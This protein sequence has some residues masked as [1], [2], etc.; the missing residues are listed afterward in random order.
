MQEY[1]VFT[2]F[3]INVVFVTLLGWYLITNLQWYDYKLSRVLFKHHKPQ[4]HIIYF[5]IPFVAYHTT[6][7]FF[8]IFFLF[9]ILPSII[10]WHKRLDK[11]L[12]LTWR[13]KRFLI[14]LVSF[15]LFQDVLCTLKDACQVY[16]VFIP[17]ALA[18]MASFTIEKFL[19]SI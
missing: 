18:Y 9:A 2:S 12:V 13:V 6:G 15:T 7:K 16:G 3:L 8:A 1:E 10:I 19:F 17:L 11:K 4:W 14:L 5:I